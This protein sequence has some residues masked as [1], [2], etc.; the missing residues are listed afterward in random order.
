MQLSSDSSYVCTLVLIRPQ[1]LIGSFDLCNVMKFEDLR[2][3][4]YEINKRS[5]VDKYQAVV[6][7]GRREIESITIPSFTDFADYNVILILKL[8]I[9]DVELMIQYPSLKLASKT[10]QMEVYDLDY[11]NNKAVTKK[12]IDSMDWTCGEAVNVTKRDVVTCSDPA[13]KNTGVALTG[14]NPPRIFGVRRSSA[15][16]VQ[17]LVVIKFSAFIDEFIDNK[18]RDI[19][20]YTAM[21]FMEKDGEFVCNLGFVDSSWLTGSAISC[22]VPP[23]QTTCH[24]DWIGSWGKRAVRYLDETGVLQTAEIVNIVI[25]PMFKENNSAG[26][27][28]LIGIEIKAKTRFIKG[29][30]GFFNVTHCKEGEVVVNGQ[31]LCK[32]DE[33]IMCYESSRIEKNKTTIYRFVFENCKE[34]PRLVTCGRTAATQNLKGLLLCNR[35]DTNMYDLLAVH[36]HN[37][38]AGYVTF[39]RV[40]YSAANF[41]FKSRVPPTI[42]S[43]VSVLKDNEMQCSASMV[44]ERWVV[45]A[46]FL[47]NLQDVF[48]TWKQNGTVDLRSW[49]VSMKS[50]ESP[51]DFIT[52]SQPDPINGNRLVLAH[53]VSEDPAFK[54][55][56]KIADYPCRFM[57][58]A[59]RQGDA[60]VNMIAITSVAEESCGV[61][62]VWSVNDTY[63]CA[64]SEQRGEM[65]GLVF[66]EMEKDYYL[67]AVPSSEKTETLTSNMS[68]PVKRYFLISTFKTWINNVSDVY[69][70]LVG[71]TT[72]K[73]LNGAGGGNGRHVKTTIKPGQKY[74]PLDGSNLTAG[75]INFGVQIDTEPYR[76][77]ISYPNKTINCHGFLIVRNWVITGRQCVFI[78]EPTSYPV[79][80]SNMKYA[81]SAIVTTRNSDV[82]LVSHV[83]YG[84]ISGNPREESYVFLKLLWPVMLGPDVAL[85]KILPAGNEQLK[86]PGTGCEIVGKIDIDLA[87]RVGF[88][89]NPFGTRKVRVLLTEVEECEKY[90]DQESAVSWNNAYCTMSPEGELEAFP[91]DKSSA[92]MCQDQ[93]EA[94]A[95]N[96]WNH[97]ENATTLRQ[98]GQHVPIGWLRLDTFQGELKTFYAENM[99]Y[100]Q[101]YKY[102]EMA[103]W[104][105][106]KFLASIQY[107]NQHLMTA[108]LISPNLL[109]TSH[110]LYKSEQ[111]VRS[112]DDLSVV[113]GRFDLRNEQE[114]N[115]RTFKI[116]KI[117]PFDD[118][119]VVVMIEEAV[120]LPWI[121]LGENVS[122]TPNACLSA[123]WPAESLTRWYHYDNFKMSNVLRESKINLTY[124][125]NDTLTTINKNGCATSPG[126]PL[127]CDGYIYGIVQN[128]SCAKD[129]TTWRNVRKIYPDLQSSV[130]EMI[131]ANGHRFKP[132][133]G[134]N[135]AVRDKY[136][137]GL[138]C[139]TV[140]DRYKC[141][142]T[143]IDERFVLTSSWCVANQ[144]SDKIKAI[145]GIPDLTR[146]YEG[147]VH[148]IVNYTIPP[149]DEIALLF[150]RQGPS[151]YSGKYSLIDL[152]KPHT[153]RNCSVFRR[154]KNVSV[155]WPSHVPNQR[156][157]LR[158][159]QM[160]THEGGICSEA[161]LHELTKKHMCTYATGEASFLKYPGGPLLCVSADKKYKIQIGVNLWGLGK[162]EDDKTPVVFVNIESFLPW[163]EHIINQTYRNEA[164]SDYGGDIVEYYEERFIYEPPNSAAFY[165]SVSSFFVLYFPIM[166]Q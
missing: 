56:P 10:A 155:G 111:I 4:V 73:T 149:N 141:A 49:T 78:E 31:K 116:F 64:S 113:V 144:S 55:A 68:E 92:L 46:M 101:N 47:C 32:T 129:R 48:E 104:G 152:K 15:K 34:D 132:P 1:W 137:S 99:A 153:G 52:F 90:Y 76:V 159:T 17:W 41:L 161:F 71:G 70:Q 3:N 106:W 77:K 16:D 62:D 21:A 40:G 58:E 93:L 30:S 5:F 121:N 63:I 120:D 107:K 66:S 27:N 7:N 134:E 127:V 165:F 154:A 158:A 123:G 74:E 80:R 160:F 79:I 86:K 102:G 145:F 18:N 8:V 39:T 2:N 157:P 59:T 29:T 110:E 126:S 112:K 163:I 9:Y 33:Y 140:N 61:Q 38:V 119:L 143:L 65:Y 128:T 13:G 67:T 138:V 11:G 37:L 45:A 105:K 100:L 146:P 97:P 164:E 156:R 89:G 54:V 19:M 72:E 88:I 142:G 95:L 91:G 108:T 150:L 25:H 23:R 148:G 87:V 14:D 162:E 81:T 98:E 124:N 147:E 51:I 83:L 84:Q 42:K 103:D 115:S 85:T 28:D 151:L 131:D 6:H 136:A 36:S 109:I 133:L 139:I 94:I 166:I 114:E 60:P 122:T 43:L 135:E 50:S 130:Q 24:K 26:E 53:L 35:F 82:C 57:D 118:S 20:N 22:S 96:I 125:D 75:N 69:D 117:E 44:D 12:R